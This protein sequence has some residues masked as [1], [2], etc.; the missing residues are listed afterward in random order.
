MPGL[1][2]IC[3]ALASGNI[4]EANEQ[5]RTVIKRIW[6]RTPQKLLDEVVPP[7]GRDDEITV[8]KFYATYLIQDYFRRFK[9]RKEVE[10]KE[11]NPQAN[12]TMS[13]Q[14]GLR[15]LQE[16]GPEIKRAISG[17]LDTDWSKDFEEPQHRVI[18]SFVNFVFS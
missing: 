8:G 1:M 5:L 3:I 6:K 12:L 13:L 10:Q 16:I 11:L 17:N 14:A 18:I 7:S 9:K 4:E 2:M 15:T